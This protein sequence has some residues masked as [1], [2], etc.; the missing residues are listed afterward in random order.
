MSLG[1]LL[2]HMGWKWCLPVLQLALAV[3]CHLYDPHEF[4]VQFMFHGAADLQEYFSQHFPAHA[5]RLE[6]AIN[7]P[8]LVLNYPLSKKTYPILYRRNSEYTYIV[9][10]PA[11]I[12]F[13]LWIVLFW[14]WVGWKLDQRRKRGP[15]TS[16]PNWVRIFGPS[17]GVLFGVLTGLYAISM[18]AG[19]WRPYQQ[20][21]AAGILWSIALTVYFTRQLTRE[22]RTSRMRS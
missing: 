7:F 19:R 1:A 17:C 20:I 15:G 9:I 18:A 13:F 14:Y 21:G 11:D 22:L 12:S 8:A 4:R 10:Y 5:G 3:A 6:K 2:T 16:L